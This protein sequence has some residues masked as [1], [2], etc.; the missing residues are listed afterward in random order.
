MIEV[1]LTNG[2]SAEVESPEEA[3]FAAQ[4]LMRE[5]APALV[6]TPESLQLRVSFFVDGQLVRG[7]LRRSE[8][9]A[10]R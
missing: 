9:G 2:D 8:L 1:V 10:F 4:T 7:D 5:A 3:V 6:G